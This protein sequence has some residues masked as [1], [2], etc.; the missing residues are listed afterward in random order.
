MRIDVHSGIA[1]DAS[2]IETQYDADDGLPKL[3]LGDAQAI[4]LTASVYGNG[5]LFSRARELRLNGYTGSICLKAPILPDQ[6][7]MARGAGANTIEPS[8]QITARTPIESWK[9][10]ASRYKTSYRTL[11][12][13][14]A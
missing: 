8:E 4:V 5:I 12:Q 2:Q 3:T 7:H 14:S 13:L 1:V 6:L 10:A 9:T 11:L